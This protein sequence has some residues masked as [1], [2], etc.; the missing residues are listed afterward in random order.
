VKNGIRQYPSAER[1]RRPFLFM[2]ESRTA[3]GPER[4]QDSHS[5]FAAHR[6]STAVPK[7]VVAA[8]IY[9]FFAATSKSNGESLDRRSR[10][11]LLT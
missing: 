8:T 5:A 7:S 2:P 4:S 9:Y 1:I 6:R 3:L 11:K 10:E